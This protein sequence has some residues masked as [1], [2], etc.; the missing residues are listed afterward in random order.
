[1]PNHEEHCE[2][3]FKR[4]GVKGEDIHT[5]LDE[6]CRLVGQGHREFRHDTKTIKLVGDIFGEKYG[7]ELAESIALDHLTADHEDEIKKRNNDIVIMKCPNCGGKLP[8]EAAGNR[9]CDYC[10][11]ESK[12][13]NLHQS[14]NI[15]TIKLPNKHH[16]VLLYRE[17]ANEKIPL[18]L[19]PLDING[20]YNLGSGSNSV[21]DEIYSDF[22][23]KGKVEMLL[24]HALNYFPLTVSDL[25]LSQY[26]NKTDS[27]IKSLILESKKVT[28]EQIKELLQR[29]EVKQF[30]ESYRQESLKDEI[31]Q[32][33][34]QKVKLL[35]PFVIV[36][37]G[38]VIANPFSY[39]LGYTLMYTLGGFLVGTGVLLII[40]KGKK[41]GF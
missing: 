5:F 25:R 35:V 17:S 36:F 19:P 8:K 26:G 12:L 34:N 7:R 28:T 41:Y 20:P 9:K 24:I 29:S 38:F 30:Q 1:M 18:V 3:S 10:G 16:T 22:E 14:E 11:F 6:P 40:E 39:E 4:Y 37:L 13:S 27:Q 32:K 21:I 2:H 31:S 15:S 23:D 33:R